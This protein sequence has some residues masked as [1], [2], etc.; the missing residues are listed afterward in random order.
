MS[1]QSFYPN[2]GALVSLDD[3]PEAL[4]F[5]ESGLQKALDKIYY[6]DL[7][8]AK[9]HD[10][11]QAYYDLVLVTNEPIQLDLFN[12]GLALVLN[13]GNTGETL[14]P[15]SLSYRWGILAFIKKF[16]PQ[17]FSFL[18]TDIQD[19]L[20]KVLTLG[21]TDFIQIAVKIFE[22]D[23]SLAAYQRLV[24]KVNQQYNLIGSD[25]IAYP[26]DAP[27]LDMAEDIRHYI[28]SSTTFNHNIP[29]VIRAIYIAST[30]IS[31]H[32][33]NLGK[34]LFNITGENLEDY[35]KKIIIPQID[36]SLHLSLG[37]SFPRNILVPIDTNTNTPLP[38]PAQSILVFD[39]GHLTFS[40]QGGIGFD[41]E[42]SVSLNYPSQIGNTGLKVDIQRV[43]LDLSRNNSINEVYLDGRSDDFI[44]VYAEKVAITLPPKWFKKETGQTIA[45]VGENL[46]IGTGGMSG[47]ITL[48][49]TEAR[50]D[51]GLVTDYYSNY[52]QLNYPIKTVSEN[53]ETQIPAYGELLTYINNLAEGQQLHF[54]YPIQITTG[55]QSI[56][57]ESESEYN[58]LLSRIDPDQFMWFQLGSNPD[59]AWR[60]GFNY[61]DLT[62]SQGQVTESNLKAR[63][64]LPKFKKKGSSDE[65]T[66][67]DLDGHWYSS[68]D[69]SL[70]ASFLPNGLPLNLFDFVTINFLSAELGKADDRFFLGTSCEISFENEVMSKI[71][72]DQK[73]V[74]PNL[75]VYEDGSLEIA[76][77]NAFIPANI[78][79]NLGPVEIAVTGIHF[80]SHQQ[81]HN[82]VMRQYNYWGFDGAISLD[83]LGIDARG[84]GIKYYYTTDN[85]A[86]GGS[87]DS[88][89]RIQTIEVDLVI[90]G[91][92]SPTAATAI[93]HGMLSIPEPGASPEYLGEVSIKLPQTGV[94]GG[95][96]MKLQ[97][98][99][100]AFLLDAYV[101]LPAPIPIGP[102]GLYGF[103]GMLGFRYVAEKEAVG[104]KS[105]ED[106]WYDY[107]THPPRGIH[108]S[109]FSGPER[110]KDYTLPFSIGAG[111]VLGTSFDNGVSISVRTMLVLSLPSLFLIE[112]KASL[113]S[114]RLGLTDDREPPFF[115][116]I[117]WGDRSIEMGMG[118]D[119]KLPEGDGWI[120][121]LYAEVQAAFFFDNPSNW[122]INFGTKENPNT[123]R[124]LTLV[125]AQS[126]LTI[127][128]RGI[129]AGARAELDLQKRFGPAKVR[130]NA[131]L[132][133]GGFISFERFQLGGY[134]KL[135]GAI[136]VDVWIIGVSLEL[137]T[138]LSAEA[139]RPFLLYAEL[140]I[141][142]CVKVIF[143]KICANVSVRLK[144]EKN[145]ELDN[146]PIAPLPHA[147]VNQQTDRTK[148]LVQGVHM[149]TNE[150]FALN[151]LGLNLSGIP[152]AA[153]ITQI[154]PL[155]TYIDIK[156]VKGL[157][158]NKVSGKIGGHT[159]AAANYTDLI[160]PQKV[161]AGRELRQVK[162]KYSIEDIEIK[163]WDG[164]NWVDYH[165]FAALV[166]DGTERTNVQGLKIGYWQRSG[167]QYNTIRLLATNPFSFTEASEPGWFIP[168]QYGITPSELFCE[169]PKKD[170]ECAN[171]LNKAVGTTYYPPTQYIAHYINGA[172]FTMEGGYNIE[173]EVNPDG[174]KRFIRS[175]AYFEVT[176]V[177]NSFGLAKS[178]SF[179]HD[180][181][182][183]VILPEAS[184]NVKL[185]LS[186][187]TQGVTLTYY[188]SAGTLDYKTVYEQVGQEYKSS[189]QLQEEVLYEAPADVLINKIVIEP[190]QHGTPIAVEPFAAR[191]FQGI[192]YVHHERFQTSLHEVCWLSLEGFEYNQTIPGQDAVNGEQQALKEGAEKTVQPIWRPNTAYYMRFRLK[193]EVDN[194][195]KEGIFDYYYGFKTA[196]PVGHFHNAPG[197][198]YGNEYDQ[199]G[200]INRKDDNG[201]FALDGK[202]VN[203]DRF[204]LTSLRQYIDYNR[205]YPNADG[206]LLQTKPLFYGHEQCKITVYFSKPLAYHMLSPWPKY[207]ELPPLAGEL[208]IA[209]K[210]PVSNVVIPYPLPADYNEESVPT[211]QDGQTWENDN[212][213]R[214][215]LGLKGINQMIAHIQANNDFIKCQL[216]LG[217]PI[218]PNSYAYGVTLTNLKPRK[219]YTALLYNAF[220]KNSSNSLEDT[221]SSQVHQFVFQTSRYANFQE[222][223][224]SYMLKELD[225]NGVLVQ[226]RQAVFDLPLIL[227]T[228]AIDL[229]YAMTT[230]DQT[231]GGSN[232][233]TQYQH[234]F[235]RTLEGILGIQPMD[236]AQSTEFNIIRNSTT[237][238]I[239][240]LLIRNPEPFNIPKIPE[241]E[242]KR[243]STQEGTIEVITNNG[244]VDTNYHVLHS[245]DYSQAL[246]MHS[247]K[248]IAGNVL[249]FRFQYKTW[250]GSTYAVNDTISVNNIQLNQ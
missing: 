237:G 222:Q 31:T 141:R 50:D 200:N 137:N 45:I 54:K 101:D 34:L 149:L 202:L 109:K 30:D 28:T 3:F 119:L 52:F 217:E 71:I 131:Y 46:L 180:N 192:Y 110:T 9:T 122:Y 183:V 39:A 61:F 55:S 214:I 225:D 218:Q 88:F 159:G 58:N 248:K 89:L 152:N 227:D 11:S 21:D 199:E 189:S 22:Q 156:T 236:P 32:A 135:G 98:R 97:P 56:T 230:G 42:M 232:L 64:E 198:T 130:L 24:D 118:A 224:E 17:N 146:T 193:D 26:A 81:E 8:V 113:L 158:P 196:G 124:V 195:A 18:P 125:T 99:H 250:N 187:E 190:G 35:I 138:I 194:G 182:L 94:A 27:S 5:L 112:G 148:E 33:S 191:T 90:P 15:I 242:I 165:P 170:F 188:K 206:N 174:T 41:K 220:D 143:K 95:A 173:V 10:A 60:V 12:T 140:K 53:G 74:L 150:S 166:E 167:E 247:T 144:W 38:D 208:H 239:I 13:P 212:D 14:I 29:E 68:E 77:G 151:Y 6:K 116:F 49:A 106:T 20:D 246:V 142:A 121:D 72:G 129:E 79:L 238:D 91:D 139:A 203:P 47:T 164:N 210:D 75:R 184:K 204:P 63:L 92:A 249:N 228:P 178:L 78:S 132:E 4:Q 93:I 107:F 67:I 104:L 161:V 171:V 1:N 85:D 48:K 243:T 76:G 245:K 172:Y 162:H 87:G 216:T 136:D 65:K 23:E 169:S 154:I 62:F 126:Y 145:G 244:T 117:A 179:D 7:Q 231:A 186:T 66:V 181:Q 240:A 223:V 43:K 19:I 70:T 73:I 201:N 213:P 163:A 83:P 86:H 160:P 235:D 155:D 105:G 229:A 120:F 127:S 36:A 176:E 219:L 226:E 207:G 108:A 69:F 134:V 57:L 40:T 100:P 234:L 168:E 211:A 241:D 123:A 133:L 44:G 233:A 114:A 2:L 96:A 16:S 82:G 111:A 205:S 185:K 128:A 25:Q 84:E 37:L 215:P 221:E 147:Q 157:I 51:Q 103:R 209:I 197:V 80:G 59:K 175:E 102:L 153:D 115:A 177:S